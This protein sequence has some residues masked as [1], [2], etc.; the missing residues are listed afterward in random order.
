VPCPPTTKPRLRV[1]ARPGSCPKQALEGLHCFVDHLV[2]VFGAVSAFG[3][4]DAVADVFV[5][6]PEGDGLE[7]FGDRRRSG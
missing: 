4:G 2:R 1:V 5:E 3:V 6:Q 7:G